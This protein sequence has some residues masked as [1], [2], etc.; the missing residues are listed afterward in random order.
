M[1]FRFLAHEAGGFIKGSSFSDPL[2]PFMVYCFCALGGRGIN[3]A[4]ST[5]AWPKCSKGEIAEVKGFVIC[6]TRDLGFFSVK[7][8]WK[9]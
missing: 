3:Q 6:L 9:N 4:S 7:E 1:L 8:G 2:T 5:C